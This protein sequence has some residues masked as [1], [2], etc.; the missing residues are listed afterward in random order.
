MKRFL[1][2]NEG[3]W[4]LVHPL[5][6]GAAVIPPRSCGAASPCPRLLA[7]STSGSASVP[8]QAHR[9]FLRTPGHQPYD[10]RIIQNFRVL[11]S[12]LAHP[13]YEEKLLLL[14]FHKDVWC[15]IP[16]IVHLGILQ[17]SPHSLNGSDGRPHGCGWRFRETSPYPPPFFTRW[18]RPT[19]S[20]ANPLHSCPLPA[21]H[22]HGRP[23]SPL[24]VSSTPVKLP[25]RPALP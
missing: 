24:H 10:T 25:R 19:A 14:L 11:R 3:V 6:S 12:G 15:F 16:C 8:S 23:V 22:V 1:E 13:P 5:L 20:L 4:S 7:S 18:M 17:E 2:E 21:V 9:R